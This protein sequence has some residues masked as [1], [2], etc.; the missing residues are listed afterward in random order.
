[1]S[2]ADWRRLGSVLVDTG[3]IRIA[4]PA[5]DELGAGLT[6]QTCHGDGE[7]H[8]YGRLGDCAF[9]GGRRIIEI[10]IVFD[11]APWEARVGA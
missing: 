6:I 8:V 9:V 11:G 4:D 7:Y 1:M 2:A 3:Q 10:R 5:I